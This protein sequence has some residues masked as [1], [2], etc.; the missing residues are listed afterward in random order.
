MTTLR[1]EGNYLNN[2]SY[3]ELTAECERSG[4]R[5][6]YPGAN[7]III[8]GTWDLVQQ[9]RQ[10]IHNKILEVGRNQATRQQPARQHSISNMYGDSAASS[11]YGGN[12]SSQY[13]GSTSS[14]YG[15]STFSQYGGS[16]SSQYGGSTS[17]QYGG[18]ASS[19][20]GGS[21]SSQYEASTYAPQHGGTSV[22]HQGLSTYQEDMHGQQ[23][24]NATSQPIASNFEKRKISGKLTVYQITL[25]YCLNMHSSL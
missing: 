12:T 4:V 8:E 23:T 3:T 19:Q 22:Y 24:S 5:C 17:S 10:K 18:S 1:L 20:Y 16:T 6:K 25:L 9:A 2:I 15:G 7:V 13:G 14:Q 11:Q 21:T